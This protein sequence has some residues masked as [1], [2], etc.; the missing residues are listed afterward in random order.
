MSVPAYPSYCDSGTHWIGPLPAGWLVKR[1]KAVADVRPSGVDKHTLDGEVPV[2]LCNY[3]D[4]YKND[5]I[6]ADFAFMQATATPAEIERFTLKGG[7]V[8]ITK[9]SETPDDIAAAALVEPTAAGI[10]C[11][12]HLAL[13]RPEPDQ[14]SGAFLFWSLKAPEAQ[15]QFRVRAQGITRF[16]LTTSAMGEVLVPV[17]PPA[18][19]STIAAFLDRETGKIDALVAEQERLIALLKEKR[20]AVISQAVTKGLDP[21]APMKDSGVEW[22]GEVPASWKVLRLK[23]TGA[24]QGGSGFPHEAQGIEG[25]AL[26]FYKVADLGLSIDGI[27]IG[28]GQHTISQ[29]MADALRAKVIPAGSILYAKIGAA[30][31]LNRRRISVV[32]CCIDNNMTAFTPDQATLTTRWAW[33]WLSIID[34][35]KVV[36][37][38]AVPSLSEGDQA[39]LPILVPPIDEQCTVVSFLD[40]EIARTDNL[41]AEA[42]RAIILLKER[43]A[44]LISAAVTGKIDVRGIVADQTDRDAA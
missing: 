8:L 34:F 11:G 38:G 12:Y 13:L 35:G 26:P 36:N 18:E 5:Q 41:T 14:M 43:R 2:R 3:V 33:C 25:E 16:G 22:L 4:V 7:D 17:P 9:D 15:A 32:D 6:T 37:P 29:Q 30:L 27:T 21:N 42:E 40:A 24:V 28:E 10:V 23:Q 31:L 20:Q 39:V 44:A 19:Q 1:L